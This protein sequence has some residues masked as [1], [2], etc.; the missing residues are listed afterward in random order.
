MLFRRL[1][2]KAAQELANNPETRAKAKKVYDDEVKPRAA[3]FYKEHETEIS[4]AKDSA[5]RGAAKLA[6]KVKKKFKEE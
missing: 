1:I 6:L 4:S 2:A 3:K 5:I